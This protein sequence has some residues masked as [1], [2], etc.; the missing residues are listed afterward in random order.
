M[1]YRFATGWG[2]SEEKPDLGRMCQV[3]SSLQL[4]DIEHGG[5]WL[6]HDT[7]GTLSF[8]SPAHLIWERRDAAPVHIKGITRDRVIELW[9]KLA[10]DRIDELLREP[11]QPGNGIEPLTAAQQAERD[12]A[13]RASDR[14][15]YVLLGGERAGTRCE[16]AGCTRGTVAASLLCRVHHFE[17]VQRKPCPFDD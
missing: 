9:W 15:F 12:E 6:E 3:L 11:W 14:S 1:S 17:A 5:A 2:D 10:T 13:V 8:E 16:T 7:H 4:A